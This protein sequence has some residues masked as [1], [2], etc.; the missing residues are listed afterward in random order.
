MPSIRVYGIL[1]TTL[2]GCN[3][4]ANQGSNERALSAADSRYISLNGTP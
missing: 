4:Y 2:L 3:I 1:L